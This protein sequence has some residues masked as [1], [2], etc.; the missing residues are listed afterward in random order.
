MLIGDYDSSK[1]WQTTDEFTDISE[2]LRSEYN[3]AV[4]EDGFGEEF[5][6]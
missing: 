4:D 6:L 2:L 1:R 3:Q 5:G